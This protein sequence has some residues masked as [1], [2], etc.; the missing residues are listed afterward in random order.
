MAFS[1]VISISKESFWNVL[2]LGTANTFCAYHTGK[3]KVA[4]C[5]RCRNSICELDTNKVTS[6]SGRFR[7]GYNLCYFCY[8]ERLQRTARRMLNNSFLIFLSLVFLWLDA[9]QQLPNILQTSYMQSQ[10]LDTTNFLFIIFLGCIGSL[11]ILLCLCL[12]VYYSNK[13]KIRKVTTMYL[14]EPAN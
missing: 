6:G 12:H 14:S 13:K 1:K 9:V 4:I 11:F 3:T 10:V 2:V 7:K 5:H 8:K